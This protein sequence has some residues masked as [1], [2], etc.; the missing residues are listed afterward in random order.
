MYKDIFIGKRFYE[1]Y[2]M[3]RDER[4]VFSTYLDIFMNAAVIGCLENEQI[5]EQ[6]DESDDSR[7]RIP[8][9]VIINNR[10]EFDCIV[11]VITFI[12]NSRLGENRILEKVFIDSDD[13]MKQKQDIAESY[14]KGG[15]K[16]LYDLIMNSVKE[17]EDIMD[18]ILKLIEKPGIIEFNSNIG[19]IEDIIAKL[20]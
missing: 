2:R 20:L 14:A 15:I 10:Y 1:Y 7:N 18:N 16:K 4:G 11:N 12:H 5:F 6:D 3:L 13:S 8:Q 9:S 17:R 19:S